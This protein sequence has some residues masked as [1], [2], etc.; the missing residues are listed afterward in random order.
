M[1]NA[2]VV[3]GS[4]YFHTVEKKAYSTSHYYAIWRVGWFVSI[5]EARLREGG[6]P[7]IDVF[8]RNVGT[9]NLGIVATICHS[10]RDW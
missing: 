3:E 9:S 8:T 5:W 10:R 4:K 1:I 7:R 2:T 6:Q